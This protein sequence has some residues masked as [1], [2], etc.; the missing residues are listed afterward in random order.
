MPAELR[1][2]GAATPRAG[3]LPTPRR[4]AVDATSRR[5]AAGRRR[6]GDRRTPAPPSDERGRRRR[7]G[8]PRRPLDD[9]L[10]DPIDAHLFR[11]RGAEGDRSPAKVDARDRLEFSDARFDSD[12]FAENAV[13]ADPTLVRVPATDAGDLPLESEHQQPDFLRRAERRARWRSAPVRA[14]LGAASRCCA[15]VLASRSAITSATSLAAQLARD[16]AGA[17]GLVQGGRLHAR[18][19]APHRRRVG[20]STRSPARIGLDAFVLRSR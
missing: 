17:R 5:R 9:L 3:R 16:A 8:R 14:A 11:K 18:G 4:S 20:R 6:R 12:L 2:S 10:A 7:S 19:A 1:T 13:G 15:L